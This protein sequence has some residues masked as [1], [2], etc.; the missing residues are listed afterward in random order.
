MNFRSN[1]KFLITGEY[2]IMKGATGLAV[3][4]KPG[5]TLE[6]DRSP[7]PFIDWVSAMYNKTWFTARFQPGTFRVI[8]A[9]D[10]DTAKFLSGI[11]KKAGSLS[12]GKTDLAHSK[13]K[14]NLEFD[15]KWGMGSSSSLLSNIAYLF[16]VDAFQL[17]LKVSRGSG[18]DVVCARSAG[19]LFFTRKG[20]DFT[21][22]EAP[23]NPP[24]SRN[25]YFV[26][27]G[28]KKRSDRAVDS[29]MQ[30]RKR[31]TREVKWISELTRHIA[32]AKDIRDFE[33]YMK[34]HELVTGAVIREPVI[35]QRLFPD[36]DGQ[37]KSLGAWGGDFVMM[38]WEGTRNA[39][40]S[41]LSDKGLKTFFSFKQIIRTA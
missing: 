14:L 5:Q 19:P 3:P 15:L 41:Y 24:F 30:T 40:T 20:S 7:Q 8:E 28:D 39:L 29:F 4:L 1:G 13:I 33:Y 34:E 12:T 6:V 35:Q 2:L 10:K 23:F 38:T 18:Y 25:I 9:S 31:F 16:D 21:A 37:V 36:L 26:Y 11:F 22:V 17:H 32:S 27:L